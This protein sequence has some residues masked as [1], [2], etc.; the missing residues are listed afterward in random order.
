MKILVVGD[1]HSKVHE[2]VAAQALRK[3][4]HDVVEFK[5]SPYFAT[6]PSVIKKAQN[7]YLWG[8]LISKINNDLI[9]LVKEKKP[10]AI[11][12]YRGTH[13]LPSVLKKIRRISPETTLV[14]YNN[15]DPFSPK[16][17]RW[18]WRHF[19]NGIPDYDLMLAY[20][21]HNM[22]EYKT[23]G[24]K[25]VDLLRSWYVAENNFPAELSAEDHKKFDCDVV[26]IGHH[27]P[28]GR[29]HFLK[30]IV[31]RGVNF[32]L[33]GPGKDWVNVATQVKELQQFVPVTP[34]W[35]QDYNKALCASRIALCFLSKLNRDTYTRRCFE[36]PASG[37]FMLSEYTDDLASLYK[38]G[39]EIE[40][41]RSKAEMLEKID[42]YLKNDEKRKQIA[43]G[44]LDRV[45]KDGHDV[46]S[47]MNQLV[48]WIRDIKKG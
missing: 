33:F 29:E 27:E 30:E 13:V 3:L 15:D 18:V 44:G 9:K 20:R 38:E 2:E 36:I 37:T 11:F 7:K 43:L 32:K 34:L 35:G 17:P 23:A 42:Y 40:F 28:D 10:E 22:D 24:A 45:R 21:H 26:F 39:E 4:D 46:V 48:T 14:G 6:N 31:R 16:Q 12:I 8:P 1:W 47:R 19:L 25:R 5:W 41:F